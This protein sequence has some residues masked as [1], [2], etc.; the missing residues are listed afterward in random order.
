MHEE[1]PSQ[2]LVYKVLNVLVTE[3]L[4]GVDDPMEVGLHEFGDDVDVCVARLGLRLE[5]I[6]QSDDVVVLKEF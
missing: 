1:Q 5:N 3:L 4:P 2:D 6:H